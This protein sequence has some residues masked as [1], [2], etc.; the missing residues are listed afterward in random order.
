MSNAEVVQRFRENLK[1]DPAMRVAMRDAD[2]EDRALAIARDFGFEFTAE[3][4]RDA[5]ANDAVSD[6]DLAGVSAGGGIDYTADPMRYWGTPEYRLY[7]QGAPDE[8]G[9]RRP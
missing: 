3:D 6:A 2:T 9:N 7:F 5:L 8:P 4:V 1:T